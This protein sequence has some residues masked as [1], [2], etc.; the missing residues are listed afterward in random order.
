M[1]TKFR[2][3]HIYH[4]LSIVA[5]LGSVCFAVFRFSP[6][7]WRVLQSC[8]DL[9]LS[10]AFYFTEMLGFE[11]AVSP[12]VTKIPHGITS[13]LPIE[14]AAFK[15]QMQTFG[16][17]LINKTNAQLYFIRI[18][19][20]VSTFTQI[21]LI[22]MLPL[23][24]LGVIITV[25]YSKPNTRH[26]VDTRPLA[27]WK[28]IEDKVYRP[29]KKFIAGY[30]EFLKRDGKYLKILCVLWMYNLNIVT[31]GV[32]AMAYIFYFPLAMPRIKL[33]TQI[34]KL[35]M[36]LTVAIGFLPWWAWVIVGWVIFDKLRKSRGMQALQGYESR[37]RDFLEANPG[38]LFLVGKQRAKKTTIITDMA[39]SQ[40]A[41]YREKAKEK[42]QSRDLQFPFFP[43]IN[44]ELSIQY[45]IRRG[46]LPT[47]ARVRC[48]IRQLKRCFYGCENWETRQQKNILAR[49]EKRF[50]YTHE[51]Y[52]FPKEWTRK[53]KEAYY[54]EYG[55]LR[56][57]FIFGY[58]FE[59]Y[60][61]EYNDNLGMINIFEALEKYAQLYWIYIAP[62]LLLANYAIRTDTKRSDC[63]NFPIFD[64][65]FFRR[66]PKEIIAEYCRVLDFDAMR[67]G[68]VFEENNP[69]KDGL[70]IGVVNVME[71]AKERGNQH[72]RKGKRDDPGCNQIN[73]L[74]ELDVKMHGHAAT[75]DNY[76]FFRLL[77]DD[78]R[79]DSL[80]ADDK[81]L[82]DT[83][84]I[85]KVSEAKIVMP[86]FAVEE[87][88]YFLATKIFDKVYYTLRYLRGDNTLFVYLLKKMYRP[89][90]NHYVRIFNQYSVYTATVRVANE[91]TNEVISDK[92]KYYISTKKVYSYRFATDA[93][94]EFYHQKALRSNKGLDDFARYKDLHPSC[95]EMKEIH[96]HFY[97]QIF[98]V[99]DI[100]EISEEQRK[101]CRQMAGVK[102]VWHNRCDDDN[103]E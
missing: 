22:A 78:Q 92:G 41:I 71:V 64:D 81:D 82:C 54:R 4:I 80:A 63:G 68:K 69:N 52:I 24:M 66:D 62:T 58:D 28:K 2:R 65:D 77:M 9:G 76:T 59:R 37:N 72:T 90:Y 70:E 57:E 60:G 91:M 3:K 6:V 100:E 86:F 7:F 33:Y 26:N 56:R 43:W 67:L 30:I 93:I 29:V 12:S 102:Y 5:L 39:L 23:V 51:K 19:R 40:T 14:P 47:L 45:G 25:A 79:A 10:I 53:E 11:G 18:G 15:I 101:R 83:L 84:T 50:G 55:H 74:F 97:K 75:I 8:K 17:M 98:D 103:A 44:L 96:G 27:V 35:A 49:L 42:L 94:S 89:I 13:V 99:F 46:S 31:I 61:A 87:I 32:E 38:A 73:D 21:I 36:D 88:G 95:E 85:K 20:G 48:Y 16:N 1:K 34:V